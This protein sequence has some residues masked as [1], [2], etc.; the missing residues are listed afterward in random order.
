MGLVA[1]KNMLEEDFDATGFE[2]NNYVGGLWRFNEGENITSIT[3]S[4]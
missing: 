1:L 4:T 2:K 3:E